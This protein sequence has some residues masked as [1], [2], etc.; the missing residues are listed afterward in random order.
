[1]EEVVV[2]GVVED[3]VED[4]VD[5]DVELLEAPPEDASPPPPQAA[6][7]S[8][9]S[10]AAIESF[11]IVCIPCIQ[12]EAID[13]CVPTRRGGARRRG[14]R[15]AR[16]RQGPVRVN[17][18]AGKDGHLESSSYDNYVNVFTSTNSRAFS[19]E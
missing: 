13:A 19:R 17:L 1:V 12:N 4:V 2:P 7:V 15:A 9:S 16:L 5:V 18:S 6:R 8:A 11:D 10:A 3:V 14:R